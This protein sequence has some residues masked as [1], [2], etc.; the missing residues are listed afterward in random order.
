MTKCFSF[1]CVIGTWTT[2]C[3]F[4]HWFDYPVVVN[5]CKSHAFVLSTKNLHYITTHRE[6]TK[7]W[8]ADYAFYS[9]VILNAYLKKC[10]LLIF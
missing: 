7:I 6:L 10:F 1:V 4:F 5:C 9:M 3:C 2:F 8:L